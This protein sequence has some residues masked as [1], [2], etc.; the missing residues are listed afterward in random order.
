MLLMIQKQLSGEELIIFKWGQRQ[1]W[2]REGN[3]SQEHRQRGAQE[4]L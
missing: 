2:G 3:T 1:P 4:S